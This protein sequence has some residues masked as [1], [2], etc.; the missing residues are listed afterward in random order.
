[1]D[2]INEYVSYWD[3][4]HKRW[5]S[6]ALKEQF[7]NNSVYNW[8]IPI[9]KKDNYFN[10]NPI[11]R[12]FPEPFWGKPSNN[13]LTA[14][15]LNINP[16]GGGDCQDILSKDISKSIL[17]ATYKKNRKTY[18]STVEHLSKNLCY[19]TSN[20]FERKRV[21]WLNKLLNCNAVIEIKCT[22]D[23]ILC[24]DLIPWHT[25]NVNSTIKNYISK[26]SKLIFDRVIDPITSISQLAT[27]K[28]LVFAKGKDTKEMFIALRVKQIEQYKNSKFEINLFEHNNAKILI[29]VGG[30]GMSLPNPCEKK[31]Q[32]E[33]KKTMLSVLEI[34]NKLKDENT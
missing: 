29:F 26:N 10:P 22:L 15:F 3:K 2:I 25:P 18:S 8:P 17:F 21:V 11:W 6:S 24:A 13:N 30:Q 32:S 4:W 7:K 31:Y 12:Y 5:Y 20:W 27:Y 9:E 19:L 34:I 1:M 28:G 33:N 23:N 16:G 14:V